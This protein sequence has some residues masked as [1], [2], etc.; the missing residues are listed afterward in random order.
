M[1]DDS[2]LCVVI[3]EFKMKFETIKHRKNT[4]ENIGK[5]GLS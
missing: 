5:R 2:S 3:M 1:N 4:D